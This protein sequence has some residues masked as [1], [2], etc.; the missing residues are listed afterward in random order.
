MNLL[1]LAETLTKTVPAGLSFAST[2]RNIYIR[3]GPES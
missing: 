2:L 3:T 1:L